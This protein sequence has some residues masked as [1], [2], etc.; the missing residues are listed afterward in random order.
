MTRTL[1]H[2]IKALHGIPWGEVHWFWTY[3]RFYFDC[4][5]MHSADNDLCIPLPIFLRKFTVIILPSY[6]STA[7]IWYV[8]GFQCIDFTRWRKSVLKIFVQTSSCFTKKLSVALQLIWN[9][10]NFIFNLF[11][12][13]FSA[14]VPIHNVLITGDSGKRSCSKHRYSRH[15][16]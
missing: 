7:K 13:N 1:L 9:K 2:L 11:P 6:N 14:K 12:R 5:H 8:A 4:M 3:Q 16:I 10:I 15:F